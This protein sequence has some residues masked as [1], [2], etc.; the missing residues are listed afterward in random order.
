[1]AGGELPHRDQRSPALGSAR[2]GLAQQR[3][4]GGFPAR[5]A[6]A[7]AAA[8]AVFLCYY[9]TL[10]PGLD[11]GDSASF[12]TAAGSLT[13][14][15]RQAYPLYYALGS[16]FVRLDPQGPAHAM[17]LA[18]AV[19]GA[20]AVAAAVWVAVEL[21]GSTLA[22]LTTGLFLGFSYTFWTQA[23]TA[24]VY[25]LHL[26]LTGSA[27][28]ALLRWSNRPTTRNLALFYAIYAVSF[29]NHLSMVLLLPAFAVFILLH[30]RR[31][32]IDPLRPKS[33]AMAIGIAALGALQYAWNFRGMWTELEPPPSF[34]FAVQ[35]FWMDVTKADWRETLIMTV[36]PQG[37]ENRPLV[38]WFDLRQQFGTPGL[39]L[40]LFGFAWLAAR[41]PRRAILLG[42]IYTANLAFGWTYNV[43]DAYIFFL[44][45]HYVVA[46]CAGA[47]VMAVAW[48]ASRVSSR[49][50][51]TYASALCLL[52]PIWRGYDTFPAADRRSDRRAIEV[53]DRFTTVSESAA[54]GVDW[55]WQVQNA[56][57][58]YFRE[59]KP[60][61]SWFTTWDLP[62][63]TTGD[64]PGRLQ[65]LI[66]A[67]LGM[68]RR[69]L[70]TP[71]V[72]RKIVAFGY[73]GGATADP[74][75][76]EID[77][78]RDG[79][80][81]V[82]TV[83]RPQAEF[84]LDR[85]ALTQVWSRL[86]GPDEE[87]PDLRT[88]AVVLGRVGQRPALMEARDRP[89]RIQPA[90]D[91]TTYDIRVTSWLPTDTIR[92]AGFGHVI[93]DRKRVLMIE[94]GISFA[95]LG[96]QNSVVLTA[97]SHNIY[98]PI[99]RLILGIRARP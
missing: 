86:V 68:G 91:G 43:G 23:V 71:D 84:P 93:V 76:P 89:F 24:E 13:L 85:T 31:S 37:L 6:A 3:V 38:Y 59:H 98:A 9:A 42:L 29:G 39:V 54:F 5:T 21:T 46:L 27:I 33:L 19:F 81:F 66:D 44:P 40:A 30:R 79:A 10:L 64:A 47:G 20:A 92:R 74:Q 12:Q 90:I 49:M 61:V 26:F 83:L 73:R 34:A 58:Y 60:D 41:R 69:I 17:N 62:W 67:N 22:G 87:I 2:A 52:Y 65:E 77:S 94:R 96:P 8:L 55:E 50:L 1:V 35:K 88:Y 95:A 56:F 80:P 53:L 63:L 7:A 78:L 97:Y 45:S 82:L 57:D 11:L 36:S 48:M 32:A 14:T 15:P 25:T 72:Y 4:S 75:A 18:S 99:P 16:V 28:A 70:V 51:A